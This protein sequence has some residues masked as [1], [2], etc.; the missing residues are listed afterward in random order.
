MACAFFLFFFRIGLASVGLEHHWNFLL[1]GGHYVRRVFE[2]G[3]DKRNFNPNCA[4]FL[5]IYMLAIFVFSYKY[6]RHRLPS[7]YFPPLLYLFL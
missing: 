7:L 2:L 4:F 5:F 1:W 3:N 6:L